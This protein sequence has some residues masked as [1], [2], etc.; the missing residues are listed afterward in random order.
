M[1]LEQMA[2]QLASDQRF[3]QFTDSL[4]TVYRP[5]P[6][7]RNLQKLQWPMPPR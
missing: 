1:Q 7:D 3:R 4:L 2:M 6:I 5:I